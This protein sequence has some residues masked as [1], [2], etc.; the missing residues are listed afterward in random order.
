EDGA[1]VSPSL[2]NDVRPYSY[3]EISLCTNTNI[4][5]GIRRA[6]EILTNALTIRRNAVWVAIVL[7]DGAADAAFTTN[8]FSYDSPP[9]NYRE[10]GFC[11]WSTFCYYNPARVDELY[12]L[13]PDGSYNIVYPPSYEECIDAFA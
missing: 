3:Q 8:Q 12:Q 4:G 1:L 7:T 2:A 11:P 6:N 10:G 13:E 9:E 5:D